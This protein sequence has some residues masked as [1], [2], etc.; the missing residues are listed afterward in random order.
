[1]IYDI[2]NVKLSH[3]SFSWANGLYAVIEK[4]GDELRICQI[5]ENGKPYIFDD[6]RFSITSIMNNKEVHET[7]LKLEYHILID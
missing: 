2:V 3:R 4:R 1:M 6:G 7:P 5:D